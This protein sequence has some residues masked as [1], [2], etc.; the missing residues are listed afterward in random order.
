MIENRPLLL[1]TERDTQKEIV[2][3]TEE[4]LEAM[5]RVII[6]NDEVTPYEFVILILIRVFEITPMIAEHITHSAHTKGLAYVTSLPKKEAQRRV[7]KAHFAAS[8][9]GFPLHFTIEPE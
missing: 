6:H 4:S 5:W 2:A 7:N 8:L 1:Q 3:D 9:E